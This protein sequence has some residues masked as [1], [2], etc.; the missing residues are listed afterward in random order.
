[1][2]VTLLSNLNFPSNGVAHSAA[3]AIRPSVLR[4]RDD[5]HTGEGG[6]LVGRK[7]VWELRSNSAIYAGRR[8]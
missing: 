7:R 3:S 1:M 6:V 8:Y 5:P 2:D 4:R